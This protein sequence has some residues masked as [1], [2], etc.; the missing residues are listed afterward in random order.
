MGSYQEWLRLEETLKIHL[1]QAAVVVIDLWEAKELGTKQ[2]PLHLCVWMVFTQSCYQTKQSLKR[3]LDHNLDSFGTCL[4][5]T[6][7]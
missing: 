1:V 4:W 7:S 3:S 5:D 6:G 2:R